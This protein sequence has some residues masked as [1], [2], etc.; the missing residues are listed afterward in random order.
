YWD[1]VG[2]DNIGEIRL[3]NIDEDELDRKRMSDLFVSEIGDARHLKNYADKSVDL[4]HSNSVIEHVGPWQDMSAMASELLRVGRSGWVQT[5][6]WEF[7]I[8]PHFRLPLLHWFAPPVRRALLRASRD[9]GSSDI[10]SRRYH[11]D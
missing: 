7:P 1:N 6:A 8:E 11:V 3:L 9:Y 10:K 2:Y 4:V 5:P